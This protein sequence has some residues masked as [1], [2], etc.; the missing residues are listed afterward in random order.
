MLFAA[1]TKLV[2]GSQEVTLAKDTELS[3]A[4]EESEKLFVGLLV[5]SHPDNFRVNKHNLRF[6]YDARN[7]SVL[8]WND[9]VEIKG[10]TVEDLRDPDEAKKF[11]LASQFA[12]I[13]EKRTKAE[14]KKIAAQQAKE[15]ELAKIAALEAAENEG[16]PP[17]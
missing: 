1:G 9:Q 4:G 16:A 5:T 11:G 10:L 12:P 17:R 7:A 2:F 13:W 6:A 8:P 15:E 14:Q 3:F